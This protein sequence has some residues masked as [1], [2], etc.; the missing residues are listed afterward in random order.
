MTYWID[1]I[2]TKFIK[3]VEIE[4][5]IGKNIENEENDLENTGS[6]VIDENIYKM[7]ESRFKKDDKMVGRRKQHASNNLF[8]SET[9][10]KY[11]ETKKLMV[12]VI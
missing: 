6:K 4:K 12:I 1:R 5:E 8:K 7:V 10:K 9:D 3:R 11:N 2:K